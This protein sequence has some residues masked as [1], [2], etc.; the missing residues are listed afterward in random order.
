MNLEKA[1]TIVAFSRHQGR[2]VQQQRTAAGFPARRPSLRTYASLLAA[3]VASDDFRVPG[4]DRPRTYVA[5]RSQR[6]WNQ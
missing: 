3:I 4:R 1:A 2:S 5:R 6:Y